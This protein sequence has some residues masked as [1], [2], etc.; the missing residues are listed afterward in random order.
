MQCNLK[1][2]EKKKEY[3]DYHKFR[4]DLKKAVSNQ[5]T[6][7]TTSDFYKIADRIFKL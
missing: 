7:L 5:I 1:S 4:Y 6:D 3:E 2:L